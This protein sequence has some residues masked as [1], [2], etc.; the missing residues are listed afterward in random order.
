M[1]AWDAVTARILESLG[2]PAVATTSSGVANA[3]GYADGGNVPRGIML[4]AIASIARV[5]SVPVT[6]DMEYGY[7]TTVEAAVDTARGVIDAGAVGLNFE[8][9]ADG[10]LIDTNLQSE[11]I[12]AMRNE[13][14]LKGVP[15]VINARTDAYWHGTSDD[16]A[17][18]DAAI[19]RG[20]A[21]IAA[22]AD[23]I[24]IPGLAKPDLIERVVQ[25]LGRI[26]ILAL[27][28]VPPLADLQ[29]LGVARVSFGSSPMLYAMASFRDAAA[30]VRD[31]GDTSFVAKRMPYDEANALFT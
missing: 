20:K 15:I 7:G 30:A 3:C 31:R 29:R 19:A 16:D 12:A 9:E 1:N 2:Y 18:L 26:N 10:K 11:R 22:G 4:E 25:A 21:Y 23:C 17:N 27:P 24:F 8:D 5:C 13:G 6:A 28:D 14:M